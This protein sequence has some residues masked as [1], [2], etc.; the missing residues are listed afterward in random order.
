[1]KRIDDKYGE[2]DY[3]IVATLPSM[4]CSNV[5]IATSLVFTSQCVLVLSE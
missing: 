4:V 2:E 5:D 3:L 1:M